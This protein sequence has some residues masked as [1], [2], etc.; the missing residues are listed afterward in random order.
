MKAFG[1]SANHDGDTHVYATLT[2][3]IP[4]KFARLFEHV[5]A[6]PRSPEPRVAP[7]APSIDVGA[8]VRGI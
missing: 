7:A 5:G 3:F 2:R 8:K 4:G 6:T 1:S